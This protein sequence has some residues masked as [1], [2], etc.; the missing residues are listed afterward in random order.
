MQVYFT[1]GYQV[2]VVQAMIAENKK[3][4]QQRL[5]DHPVHDEDVAQKSHHANDRVERRDGYGYDYTR[6]APHRTLL[7]LLLGGVQQPVPHQAALIVREGDIIRDDGVEVGQGELSS[8]DRVR[9]HAA[10]T[11][12]S[13]CGAENLRVKMYLKEVNY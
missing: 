7:L 12:G 11:A 8:R 5:P 6:G 2:S 4:N 13:D 10:A 1:Q 9:L 3:Q